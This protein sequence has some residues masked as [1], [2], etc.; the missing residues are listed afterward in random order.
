MDYDNQDM[1]FMRRDA[2]RRTREMHR[3]GDQRYNVQAHPPHTAIPIHNESESDFQNAAE[4]CTPQMQSLPE[5][6]FK[7]KQGSIFSG[8]FSGENT[9]SD[10]ILIIALIVILSKEGADLKLLIALGYILM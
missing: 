1:N 8:L 7:K 6:N 9:D 10:L 5:R 4:N 3:Q 2:L